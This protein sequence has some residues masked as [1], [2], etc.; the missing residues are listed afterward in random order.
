MSINRIK[1]DNFLEIY[2]HLADLKRANLNLP[3]V[4]KSKKLS[5]LILLIRIVENTSSYGSHDQ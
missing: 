1:T 4:Y 3:S 5:V 2:K